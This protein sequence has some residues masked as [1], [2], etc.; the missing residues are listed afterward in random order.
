M[1]LDAGAE[2]DIITAIHLNDL[3]RVKT[4]LNASPEFANHFRRA[5]P[6][7]KAAELGHLEIC[8]YLIGEHHVDVNDF[9]GGVGYPIIKSALAHPDVV[10]L[11]IENGADL[12]TRITWRGG[13][14]GVWFIGDEATALHHAACDGVPE[15]I[16]LLID[17]G[18]D[19]FTHSL[20]GPQ[21]TDYQ[22]ALEVAA[23]FGKADNA[24]AILRHPQFSQADAQVRQALLD[25]CLLIGAFPF[26][27]LLLRGQERPKLIKVLLEHGAHPNVTKDRLTAMLIAVRTIHP[28]DDKENREV[29]DIVASLIG[30]GATLDLFSAVAIGDQSQ[31]SRC[32]SRS[33]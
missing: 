21:E 18:V 3:N 31:V 20:P 29:K 11:L 8:R 24:R 26:S 17:N 1:L 15:T 16:D 2:Y 28:D 10:R 22:T 5:S 4:I 7:R 6:L 12:K 33:E 23:L 14:S 27:S 19:I 25:K 32:T 9:E 13:R 30:H